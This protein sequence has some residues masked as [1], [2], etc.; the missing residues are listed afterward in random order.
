M[1]KIIIFL[2]LVFSF[3]LYAESDNSLIHRSLKVFHSLK[4]KTDKITIRKFTDKDFIG[5]DGKEYKNLT[6]FLKLNIAGEIFYRK[7][8]QK[9]LFKN[10]NKTL[11]LPYA[12]GIGIGLIVGILIAK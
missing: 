2:L 1:K 8:K 7:L 11:I 3:N 12:I 6:Y 5:E 10:K 4:K 9:I